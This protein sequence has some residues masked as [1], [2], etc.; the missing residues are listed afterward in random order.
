MYIYIK[1]LF[2]ELLW[3][4]KKNSNGDITLQTIEIWIH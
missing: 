3:D 2:W 4:L 1:G